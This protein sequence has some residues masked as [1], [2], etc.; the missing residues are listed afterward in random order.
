MHQ[1]LRRLWHAIR[2]RRFELDLS[3]EMEFHRA[4][5]QHELE[6]RGLELAKAA[7]A[8]RRAL[9]SVALAQDR[10]RD[11]WLPVWLQGIGQD[12]RHAIRALCGT[13]IVTSV[14][15]LSLALGIGANTAMFSLV[16]SLLLRDI[17]VREPGRLAILLEDGQD[18]SWTN[19]IWE[20]IRNRSDLFDGTFAWAADRF[21]LAQGGEAQ[22]VNGIWAS[23]SFFSVLGV[24]ALVGRTLTTDDDRRGGGEEGAVAVIGYGFWMRQFGGAANVIGRHITLGR[25]PFTIV[26][27]TPPGFFGPDV[28][29]TFDVIVPLGTEPLLR[30]KDSDLDERWSWW[31]NVM[32]RLKPGQSLEGA[33]AILRDTQERI[34][35]ATLPTYG[36]LD[37]YLRRRMTL[38][39]APTGR[40]PLRSRYQRSLLTLLVVVALV[41][42]IACANI[43][44]LLLARA[45]ARRHELSVRVALGAAR[46]RLG[47]QLLIESLTLSCVGAAI[48][49]LLAQLGTRLIVAQL[50]TQ[51]NP[52]FLDLAPDWR[53]LG[54]TTAVTVLT[55]LVFGTA[56]A[57]RASRVAAI[58]AMRDRGA[59]AG[60]S[61]QGVAGGLVVAQVALSL[62]LVLASGL[63]VR[64]FESLAAVPLGFDA[65]Q[66]LLVNLDAPQATGLKDRDLGALYDRVLLAVKEAPGVSDVA[67]SRMAPFTAGQ[68][69]NAPLSVE[70][71][72]TPSERRAT[73]MNAITPQWFVAA[74]TPLVA[75]R[76]FNDGDRIGSAPVAIVN[77]AFARRFG[78]GANPV[79]RIILINDLG[80]AQI[81]GRMQI[82]GLA[83]DAVYRALREPTPATVYVPLSQREVGSSITVIVRTAVS[84]P[85][86]LAKAVGAA[87]SHVDRDLVVT[88]RPLAEHVKATLIQERLLAMLSAF[89]ALLA[90]LLA[91]LGLYGVTSYAVSRRR[92]EIGIRMALGAAQGSVVRLVLS[93]VLLLVGAGVIVG[94]AASLW[95]SRFVA[96]LLYSLEPHDP[97]T[98]VGAIVIL[99]V[100][101]GFAA[102]LPAWRASRI[103]PAAVLRDQ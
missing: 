20:D 12:V 30:G 71:A 102:W 86:L 74:G 78:L 5:K 36:P 26:G 43:A 31:L 44:N 85:L 4:M 60:E 42:L 1:L 98:L 80:S 54:F 65:E 47:R 89:F 91:G 90:L 39:S 77:Q 21:N 22:M 75:G 10:S 59:S 11:V 101:G 94:T 68:V 17:P 46:W 13:R 88:F 48:G 82:V 38:A 35:E 58:A 93:R 72:P 84:P 52:V 33:N 97:A 96:A 6:G 16:N 81:V 14:A 69:W 25:V 40:S 76:S 19:P 73:Y 50:S 100:V 27:V 34:R 92:A 7:F 3:E 15:V 57:L 103:D 56:P 62:M 29:R 67:M 63:F 87:I 32:V 83:A 37:Q 70:G 9:G 99:V 51:T 2:Q 79:G 49:L 28:G 23:S 45:T 66:I 64:T 61:R 53:V 8:A 18:T 41:L 55:A 24:P 95:A